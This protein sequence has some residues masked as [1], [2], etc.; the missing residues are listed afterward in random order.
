[1]KEVVVL[2]MHGAPP[3]DFPV[4]EM[5]EYFMLL[6][7][8]SEEHTHHHAETGDPE[9]D[10]MISR[11]IQLEGKMRN[12]P[13][14]PENDPF[15]AGSEALARALHNVAKLDV[16]LGFNEFCGPS[17]EQALDIAVSNGAERV[18]AVTPM[19]TAGGEH[20]E[21]EIPAILAKAEQKHPSVNFVY[22]WPYPTEDVARFLSEQVGRFR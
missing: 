2:V 10:E 18:I 21:H 20:A 14:T 9:Q 1:M 19:M 7:R 12:W 16:V 3:L 4:E 8:L 15:F 11:F 6:A 5:R 22:A 13:R 17:L